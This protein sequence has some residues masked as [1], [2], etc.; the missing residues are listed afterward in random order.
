VLDGNHGPLTIT[1]EPVGEHATMES[2]RAAANVGSP[3]TEIW[4]PDDGCY[5]I[6][7]VTPETTLSVT[8]WVVFV[9]DW[10]AVPPPG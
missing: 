3:V 7:G 4:F 5:T 2:G 1:V 10:L 6:T 9:D 8:V